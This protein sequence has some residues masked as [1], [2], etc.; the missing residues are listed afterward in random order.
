MPHPQRAIRLLAI[1]GKN[2]EKNRKLSSL[3]KDMA[4]CGPLHLT[5]RCQFR[6]NEKVGG[7]ERSRTIYGIAATASLWGS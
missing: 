6:R 3:A 5:R 4:R 1:C 2:T 7:Q